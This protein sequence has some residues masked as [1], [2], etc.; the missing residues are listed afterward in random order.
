MKRFYVVK[1]I[2]GLFWKRIDYKYEEVESCISCLFNKNN[3]CRYIG[4]KVPA[5]GTIHKNCKLPPLID[6]IEYII[7]DV[8]IDNRNDS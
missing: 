4:K 8:E 1:Y 6:E 3:V 7:W 2:K 5:N